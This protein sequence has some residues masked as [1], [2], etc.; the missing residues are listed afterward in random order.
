MPKQS[1]KPGNP[2]IVGNLLDTMKKIKKG[3][4]KE[5][6]WLKKESSRFVNIRKLE[7]S[8]YYTHKYLS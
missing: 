2:G 1:R 8:S 4:V 6:F 7:L 3:N 5:I